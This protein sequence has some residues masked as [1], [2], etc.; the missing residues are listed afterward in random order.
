MNPDVELGTSGW[1]DLVRRRAGHLSPA[2]NT[3][4]SLLA[5]KD[6]GYRLVATVPRPDAVSLSDFDVS[7][8]KVALLFGTE[9]SGLSPTALELADEAVSVPMFGFVESLNIS[10]CAALC[11][12]DLTRRIRDAAIDWRLSE[13]QKNEVLLG[14]L[15]KSLKRAKVLEASFRQ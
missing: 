3:R 12:F 1:L 11:F 2:E 14:W 8:G 6:R 4:R 13:R 7:A 10:V 15:R 5:L 9:L